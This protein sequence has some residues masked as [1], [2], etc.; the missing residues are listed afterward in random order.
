MYIILFVYLCAGLSSEMKQNFY[1]RVYSSVAERGT[2]DLQ[3]TG[4]TPVA[5]SFNIRSTALHHEP[6]MCMPIHCA[7]YST[8]NAITA[9]GSK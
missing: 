8:D 4:S 3:V 1:L 9:L 2:A 7:S 6:P 5:P